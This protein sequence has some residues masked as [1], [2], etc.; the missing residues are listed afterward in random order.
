MADTATDSAATA[1]AAAGAE[2]DIFAP[3]E[4][5]GVC[6]FPIGPGQICGNTVY[7]SHGKGALPKYCGQKGQA[8]WQAQHGTEG[9]TSHQSDL[10]GYPRK[11]AGM[12]TAD[13]ARLAEEEA[14]RRGIVRRKAATESEAPATAPAA[15]TA[16][17]E[18]TPTEEATPESAGAALAALVQLLPGKVGALRE[19]IAQ[20]E[21]DRDAQVAAE[22]AKR[23]E[24]AAE[25]AAEREALAQE[26]AEAQ[27]ARERAESEI[28]EATDARLQT[29]GKLESSTARVEELER[30]LAALKVTHREEVEEVRRTEYKRFRE[31]MSDFA[32]TVRSSETP[33]V[34]QHSLPEPTQEA[35]DGMMN[36]VAHGD[37]TV[38]EGAW[39]LSNA[40]ANKAAAVTLD[41]LRD[42][43][44]L[45]IT[46]TG[47]AVPSD[48]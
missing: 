6:R 28:R 46:D 29:E 36:R 30:E 39:C 33:A 2:H 38:V 19:E 21:A 8:Q 22:I 41:R 47:Q 14:A 18:S 27:A 32:A 3:G 13:A 48:Q 12:S 7:A 10:A 24:M 11:R 31:M 15:S 25:V 1:P 40:T 5:C 37:V 34:Q 9:D 20:A 44:R 43:G 17:A 23:E 4:P 42:A 16:P 26:R 45:R 35:L